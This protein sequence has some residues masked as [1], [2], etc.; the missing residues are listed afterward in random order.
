M[1]KRAPDGHTSGTVYLPARVR[2]WRHGQF[3]GDR[4]PG[5]AGEGDAVPLARRELLLDRSVVLSDAFDPDAIA[6]VDHW[7]EMGV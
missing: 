6:N 7:V 4:L 2:G 3:R 5:G 1:F